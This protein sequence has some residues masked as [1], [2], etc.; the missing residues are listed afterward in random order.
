MTLRACCLLHGAPATPPLPGP[1]QKQQPT[2]WPVCLT[3]TN[4]PMWSTA[5]GEHKGSLGEG[6]GQQENEAAADSTCADGVHESQQG[7]AT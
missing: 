2:S 7:A 5:P 1:P 6:C 4:Y 3:R